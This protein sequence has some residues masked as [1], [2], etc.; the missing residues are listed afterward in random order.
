M[1]KSAVLAFAFTLFFQ[2]NNISISPAK[3]AD[4]NNRISIDPSIPQK[5]PLIKCR[6]S[7]MLDCVEKVMVEHIDGSL[8]EAIFV[9]TRLVDFPEENGQKVQYGDILFDFRSGNKN[10]PIKRLRI[11]THVISPTGIF[12][13]KTAGAYWIMLQREL[14]P[15]EP[16]QQ[17]KNGICSERTP[18]QCAN[19]PALDTEDIFHVY[20]RTSWLA[21]VSVS[22][23]GKK[24]NIDYRKIQGGFQWKLSGSEYLQ[25]M[26]S[27]TSK[28]TESVKPGNENMI[29]DRLNPTLYFTL[30]HGGKDLSDSYWDPSCMDKGFTRTMWNAPLAGQLFWDKATQSLNFN[31]YAPHTDPFGKEYLG[32]F[33]TKFQKAWLD[34]RF[35]DNNLSTATKLEVQVLDDKGVP[36]VSTSAVSMNNGV[37][38]ISVTGFHFS[39]PQI[40]AKRA[41]NSGSTPKLVSNFAD[42]WSENQTQTVASVTSSDMNSKKI[43]ITCTKGNLTKK[44]NGIKPTCPSGY[45]KK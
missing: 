11:S 4:V 34:C 18:L 5:S 8:E 41:A 43:T 24:F 27:D 32:V 35:P 29:P 6:S 13:G 14:L 36:Q 37:I 26:F 38:D 23:S 21:P 16:A 28:L 15:N 40:V 3:A 9:N 20:L 19:Y 44:I 2:Q 25:P 45:K 42:D 10:G 33:R 7:N 31:M 17:S 1:K 12:N 39:S 30:D 22:G